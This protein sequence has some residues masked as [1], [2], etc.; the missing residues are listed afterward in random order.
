MKYI[1]CLG[2]LFF[3]IANP[4]FSQRLESFSAGIGYIDELKEFMTASKNS[5]MEDLYKEFD[6]LYKSAWFTV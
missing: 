5:R 1:F 2:F 4:L 6:K 3:S